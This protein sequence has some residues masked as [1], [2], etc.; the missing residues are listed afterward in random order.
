[1]FSH[2]PPKPVIPT[3]MSTPLSLLDI[4]PTEIARQLTLIEFGLYRSIMP[5][6]CLG[7]AWTKTATRHEKAPNIMAMIARFNQVSRWIATEI[8][9]ETNIRRRGD[10]LNHVINIAA[11]CPF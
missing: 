6:E 10:L 7:Q 9:K 2:P 1:M 3:N 4:D 11:V 8:V 5:Q